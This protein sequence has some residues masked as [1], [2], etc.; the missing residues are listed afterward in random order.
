MIGRGVMILLR[1]QRRAGFGKCGGESSDLDEN[2]D[3]DG[4]RR[5]EKPRRGDGGGGGGDR[6][7]SVRKLE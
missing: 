6:V 5:T 4:T 2:G 7:E 3:A 1:D